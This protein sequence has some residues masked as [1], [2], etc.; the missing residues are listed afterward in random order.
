MK[1]THV[2]ICPSLAANAITANSPCVF[3]QYWVLERVSDRVLEQVLERVPDQVSE[4][5]TWCVFPCNNR[6]T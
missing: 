6:K 1:K 5:E 3:V 4:L 2:P